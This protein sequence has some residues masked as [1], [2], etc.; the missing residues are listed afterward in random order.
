MAKAAA[1]LC[2][3][4]FASLCLFV[5]S[6][7]GYSSFTLP[8][9]EGARRD[10]AW[11]WHAEPEAL[12]LPALGESD[13][14]NPS[15]ANGLLFYSVFDQKTWHTSVQGSRILSPE[16]WEGDYIA[17]NGSVVYRDNEY[18]QWYQ[19]AGP[20]EPKIGFAT[21]GNG[22]IWNKHRWPVLEGGP[23]GAWD[24]KGVG[25]PYVVD[26]GGT[27]YLFYLG[28]DRAKR[29]RIG[30]AISKDGKQWTRL[31]TNP[32]LEAGD[33]GEFD[34]NGVGEP[35][36]WS[37][38]GAWWMLYTGR[39]RNEERRMGLA[40]SLDGVKW[41]KVKGF[42]VAGDQPWN[43]KTMCDAHAEPQPNGTVKVWFGGGDKAHP[44]EG[45][46]GRVG[47]GYLTPE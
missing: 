16:A 21:S 13:A 22:T 19:A 24:E 28:Q 15:V 44:A 30:L 11:R 5:G 6:C 33:P 26:R 2:S 14:L 39:A 8:A 31:K 17:A 41:E 35:A 42:V 4:T 37:S 32:L 25:D 7:G 3:C 29:Q 10:I 9:P 20:D 18:F 12:I 46:N 47:V 45:V 34:E 38:H 43:S 40:K 36:V 27:F 1:T 23:R